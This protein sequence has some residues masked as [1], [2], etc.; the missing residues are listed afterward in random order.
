MVSGLFQLLCRTSTT[1][2][3]S[4]N[5]RSNCSRYSRLSDVFLYETGNW[6]NNAPNLPSD[7]SASSPSLT[8]ASSSSLGR[9]VAADVGSITASGECV[10]DLSSFAV[11]VKSLLT[12]ATLRHQTFATSGLIGP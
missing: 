11:K 6:I 2:G 7:A 8:C 4:I 5:C 9:M 12:L 10:N 3:Y 1:R